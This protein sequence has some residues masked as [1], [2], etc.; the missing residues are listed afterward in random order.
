MKPSGTTGQRLAAIF[1]MGCI[2]LDYP[3]LSLFSRRGEIAG[4]PLLYAF[5]FA[6]WIAL[7]GLMA[8]V[9]ERQRD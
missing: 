2:L 9:I 3:I 6:V 4:I 7:I 5:V 1:M 8:W